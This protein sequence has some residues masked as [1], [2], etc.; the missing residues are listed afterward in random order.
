[1]T[2]IAGRDARFRDRPHRVAK[3]MR[4]TPYRPRDAAARNGRGLDLLR[5]AVS[6][7]LF[8]DLEDNELVLPPQAGRLRARL[9]DLRAVREE[10]VDESGAL[11]LRVR[12][13]FSQLERLCRDAGVDPPARGR[14][15]AVI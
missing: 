5:A 12:L 3:R 2:A 1:M 13:P 9:F 15:V 7:R 8:A 10:R 4:P 11:R 6:R 14:P